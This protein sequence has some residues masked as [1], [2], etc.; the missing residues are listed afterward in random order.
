MASTSPH[1]DR[2]LALHALGSGGEHVGQVAAHVAL[3]DDPGQPAG[4]GQHR[5]QRHLGQRHGRGPVV[6][7]DDLVARQRQ[8]VAAAGRGAVD[9]GDPDLSGVVGG[10]LDARCGSRW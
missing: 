4:A 8:L 3:V 7:Q 9:R 10:V 2:L 6:D 1:V 5:Q